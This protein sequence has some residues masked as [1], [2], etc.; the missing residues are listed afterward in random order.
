MK[1]YTFPSAAAL[2]A[3]G[4]LASGCEKELE[5]FAEVQNDK[6]FPTVLANTLGTATKYAPGENVRFELQFAAQTDPISEIRILQKVE[7]GRDSTLV[8]T[9][10]YRAAFSRIRQADTLLVNYVVPTGANKANVRVD[11]VVVSSNGQTKTR[12]F[13][14]R[15][16]EATPTVS[17]GN[18]TNVTAPGTSTPVPGDVVRFPVTLNAG[19]IT[20]AANINVAGTLFKDID[21][22]VTYVRVGTQ[23]ERR[24]A[25]QRVPV[26]T[27]AQSGAATT[28]NVDLA[29]PAGS[30]GQPVVF[31]FEAKSR[32]QAQPLPATFTYRAASATAAALTPGTPTALAA[33]RTVTLTYTGT[34]GGD[35]AAY[36]LTT[37]A[38]V[39]VAGAPA[40]KDV[41]ITSIATNAVQLKALNTTKFFRSTAA[42]YSAATLNSIR[43]AYQTAA[44][45]AQVA[46]LDNVVVGDVFIARLRNVD[47]YAIFTVT[48]INRTAAGVTLTMDVKAL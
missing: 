8:Q 30:S 6:L 45:T 19:G 17:V 48:G 32:Y 35:L 47:Q 27:G 4:L 5:T 21:S 26:G 44:A 33:A 43:A 25:R 7:P 13:S 15:L 34:T 23:A 11:A 9:I 12:S 16:A 37:F 2:L 1:R 20:S 39:P 46:Q 28:V 29:L 3:V 31:R 24:Y 41:A 38:S 40:N 22:L 18:P 10:P 36:D 42:V 14:F